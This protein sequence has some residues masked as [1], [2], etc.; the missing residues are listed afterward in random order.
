[1]GANW[2]PGH[3]SAT[4]SPPNGGADVGGSYKRKALHRW[5]RSG[6]TTRPPAHPRGAGVTLMP[7]PL[8]FDGGSMVPVIGWQHKIFDTEDGVAKFLNSLGTA[9]RSA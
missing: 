7:A 9:A 1:M 3:K 6:L 5:R 2:W 8:K 4:S